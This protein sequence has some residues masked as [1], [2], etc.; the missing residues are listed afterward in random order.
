MTPTFISAG[1]EF[2]GTARPIGV[3]TAIESSAIPT[4]LI[5]PFFIYLLE[6]VAR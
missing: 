4:L 6:L 2:A 5:L 3:A 1:A